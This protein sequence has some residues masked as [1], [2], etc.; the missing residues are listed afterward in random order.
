MSC[1]VSRCLLHQ[2]HEVH[3]RPVEDREDLE[4]EEDVAVDGRSWPAARRRAS[5][6]SCSGG[7]VGFSPRSSVAQSLAIGARW[8]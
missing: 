7:N 4:R 8:R 2:D 5:S 6:A 3:A 1:Y